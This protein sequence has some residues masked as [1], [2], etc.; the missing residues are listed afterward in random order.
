MEEKRRLWNE[1]R[2]ELFETL[3]EGLHGQY[4]IPRDIGEQG[5][6]DLL[7]DT[8]LA[9]SDIRRQEL[10]A[11]NDALGRLEAGTYGI[12]ENC[13]EEIAEERLQV[14]P[15]AACCVKCQEQRERPAAALRVTL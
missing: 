6:I 5:L 10:T 4:E 1:V 11:M 15:C 8:G 3:G 12:C 2:V 9:V 13:G 14:A 7:A